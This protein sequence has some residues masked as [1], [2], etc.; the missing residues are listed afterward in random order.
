MIKIEGNDIMRGG[1][2]VGW[3]QENDIY[4]NNGRKLAYFSSNDIYKANGIKL[5]HIEGDSIHKEGGGQINLNENRK[6]V[7]GG[8]MSELERAAI[9]LIFG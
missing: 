8:S 7:S 2:K 3:I 4:D 6:Y 9:R 1:E 5:G